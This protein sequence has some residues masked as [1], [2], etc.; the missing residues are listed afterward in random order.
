MKNTCLSLQKPNI[1]WQ[2]NS[3][4]GKRKPTPRFCSRFA[5][6]CN[7]DAAE[8]ACIGGLKPNNGFAANVECGQSLS[9]KRNCLMLLQ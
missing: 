8:N 3:A 1:A 2:K 5:K 4:R 7:A 9:Q 6:M